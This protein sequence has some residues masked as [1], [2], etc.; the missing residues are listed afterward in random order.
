M[1]FWNGSV[2]WGDLM[3]RALR[4]SV[5]GLC[6]LPVCSLLAVGQSQDTAAQAKPRDLRVMSYN[7]K[8]GQTNASCTQPEPAPGQPPLADCNLDLKAALEVIRAHDPD[9]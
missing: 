3:R 8:H 5:L 9:I 4:S 7:I 2:S 6:A 1:R